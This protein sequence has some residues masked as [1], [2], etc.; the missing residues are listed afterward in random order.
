MEDLLMAQWIMT[1]PLLLWIH[2][3]SCRLRPFCT[4]AKVSDRKGPNM[5]RHLP[6]L[7]TFQGSEFWFEHSGGLAA[8]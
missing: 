2:T 4:M 6:S 3:F 1:V 7:I 5:Y 8:S